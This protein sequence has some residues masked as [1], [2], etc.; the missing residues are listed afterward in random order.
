MKIL[1]RWEFTHPLEATTCTVHHSYVE[2]YHSLAN[3][4]V[5]VNDVIFAENFAKIYGGALI[6]QPLYIEREDLCSYADCFI[7]HQDPFSSPEE[8][9][10]S[11][12]LMETR[13]GL[14]VTPSAPYPVSLMEGFLKCFTGM[15]RLTITKTI[16]M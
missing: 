6:I 10:V 4:R 8:W 15:V 14:A 7:R 13:Q 3:T 16:L 1:L 12:I 2:Q 11:F 5:L 9:N